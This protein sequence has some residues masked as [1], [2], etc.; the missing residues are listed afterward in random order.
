MTSEKSK[1]L[2]L[3]RYFYEL[4]HTHERETPLEHWI[5]IFITSLIILSIFSVMLET[6]EELEKPL[7]HIFFGFEVFTVIVFSLEY[8]L[9]LWSCVD[10]PQFK[11]PVWGRIRYMFTFM[12]LIDFLAVFPFYLP[13]IIPI[14]LRFIRGLRLFRLFRVLKLGRYSHA[15]NMITRVV[16]KKRHELAVTLFI[17]III[18]IISSSLIYYLE[19]EAQPNV[20]TSIPA[21]L[22]WGIATLTTI[23]YGDVVPMTIAGRI[24]ASII[25]ILGIGLFALPSGILV[26]GFVEEMQ[27][28]KKHPLC[29]HCGKDLLVS[30]VIHVDDSDFI[31]QNNKEINT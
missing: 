25:S 28:E 15:M 21:S 22:W 14:D 29:P 18:L 1:Y 2:H 23:G 10:E 11:H 12:A 8:L 19:H 17:I 31:K 27:S 30:G 7:E 20:F 13:A 24:C 26:A 16:K 9:R 4:L 6:V 3:R 5:R